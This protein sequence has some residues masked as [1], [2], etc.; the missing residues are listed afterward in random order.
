MQKGGDASVKPE[1][2]LKMIELAKEKSQE[3]RAHL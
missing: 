2:I 1:D 3:L